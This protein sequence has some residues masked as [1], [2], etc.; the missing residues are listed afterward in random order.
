[1]SYL[2][3]EFAV[4]FL[5]FLLLYWAL[6]RWSSAQNSLCCSRLT[7]CMHRWTGVSARRWRYTV[8]RIIV[9]CRVK[10]WSQKKLAVAG[11]DVS[12]QSG[13]F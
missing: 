8:S 12:S 6:A 11:V 10:R 5:L 1:M 4:C 3:P 7:P 2:S 9:V 13:G